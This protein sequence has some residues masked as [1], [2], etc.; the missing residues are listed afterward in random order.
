M[1]EERKL[2]LRNEIKELRDE[3]NA[4]FFVEYD[5]SPDSKIK[6]VVRA[7][8]EKKEN[9]LERVKKIENFF[10]EE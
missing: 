5:K 7:E 9:I 6:M 1:T 4:L 8:I 3:L 2:E 10:R